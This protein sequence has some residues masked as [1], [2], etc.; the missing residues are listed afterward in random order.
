[1]TKIWCQN[2]CSIFDKYNWFTGAHTE[3]EW[4]RDD[5]WC[6]CSWWC[7]IG[8]GWPGWFRIGACIEKVGF[9]SIHS[10]HHQI[11]VCWFFFMWYKIPLLL[12]RFVNTFLFHF[13]FFFAKYL[14]VFFFFGLLK[15]F[16]SFGFQIEFIK[17]NFWW[18]KLC[19]W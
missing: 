12:T 4:K 10:H 19:Y 18:Y 1:M 8:I 2:K 7:C 14:F 13:F 15:L 16:Y 17:L 3:K 9:N 5:D 11:F 6:C